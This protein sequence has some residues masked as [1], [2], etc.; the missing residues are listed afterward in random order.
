MLLSHTVNRVNLGPAVAAACRSKT[1]RARVVAARCCGVFRKSMLHTSS[2]SISPEAT[3]PAILCRFIAVILALTLAAAPAAAQIV[4]QVTAHVGCFTDY[5]QS[6]R[7]YPVGPID[8]TSQVIACMPSPA[9]CCQ[10]SFTCQQVECAAYCSILSYKHQAVECVAQLLFP[11][12]RLARAVLSFPPRVHKR[13][14]QIR[15]AMLLRD[16]FRFQRAVHSS[17]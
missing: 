9:A 8:V 6:R 7:C 17:S 3:M 4:C 2:I 11:L 5:I 1:L 10:A 14:L 12:R 13:R 15:R 16:G